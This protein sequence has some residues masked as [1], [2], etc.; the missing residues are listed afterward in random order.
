M[1]SDR[2]KSSLMKKQKLL[3]SAAAHPIQMIFSGRNKK[4]GAHTNPKKAMCFQTMKLALLVVTDNK[5]ETL[6]SNKHYDHLLIR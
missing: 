3:L 1:S 6:L 2:I 5:D 4:K